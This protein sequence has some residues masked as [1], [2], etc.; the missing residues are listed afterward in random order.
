MSV[1]KDQSTTFPN[2]ASVVSNLIS[3]PETMSKI[4]NILENIEPSKDSNNP[5]PYTNT[6]SDIED[7]SD[8]SQNNIV[9]SSDYSPT[10]QN[11]D[12]GNFIAKMPDILSNLSSLKPENSIANKQQINL[13]LAVRPYLSE[14]RKELIDSFIK[15]NKFSSIFMS[16]GK[17]GKKNVLQ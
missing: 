4:K 16:L 9:D 3:S 14:R 7:N 5:P 12:I 15:I 17:E 8:K 11:I 1:D 6:S 13:L 2:L 10:F